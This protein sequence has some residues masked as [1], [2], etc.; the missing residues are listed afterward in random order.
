M[1]GERGQ[2]L[3]GGAIYLLVDPVIICSPPRQLARSM[4]RCS[5]HAAANSGGKIQGSPHRHFRRPGRLLLA[6]RRQPRSRP[7][8]SR[9]LVVDPGRT[10]AVTEH[11]LGAVRRRRQNGHGQHFLSAR[12]WARHTFK[13]RQTSLRRRPRLEQG[14]RKQLRSR[15]LGINS[16]PERFPPRAG[17]LGAPRTRL[18]G[19]A[20]EPQTAGAV[21]GASWRR[22]TI[23]I[24][25][26]TRRHTT[27][28]RRVLLGRLAKVK[29]RR[30]NRRG[31]P[32]FRPGGGPKAQQ[33]IEQQVDGGRRPDRVPTGALSGSRSGEITTPTGGDRHGPAD[34]LDVR[35]PGGGG[36]KWRPSAEAR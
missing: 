9:R 8:G 34:R 25:H 30:F 2:G 29:P 3:R 24:V 23:S 6:V 13:G 21:Q 31:G 22:A 35:R 14:R 7:W 15:C 18:D 5:D 4:A 16:V 1:P 19:T 27:H 32:L 17:G 11:G 20:A 28:Q 26:R 33:G 12:A 10:S 36:A